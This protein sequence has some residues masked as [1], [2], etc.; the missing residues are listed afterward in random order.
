MFSQVE[1]PVLGIVE[2]MSYFVA[3]NR[4][5][6][7]D[8]RHGGARREAERLGVFFLGEVP[9]EM[10]IRETSYT[11]QPVVVSRPDGAEAAIYR[12]IATKGP[13][14]P[15]RGT[16]PNRK[17]RRRRSSSSRTA[18][19]KPPLTVSLN[20]E[21]NCPASFFEVEI[22]QPRAELGDLAADIALDE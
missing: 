12:D 1:V 13:G 18:E 15:R 10:G 7:R 6:L 22:D 21:K 14:A 5:A 9:L 2:N 19:R 20:V 11:G 8:F 4:K 3:R 16:R 17:A